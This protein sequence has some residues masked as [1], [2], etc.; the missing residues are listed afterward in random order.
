MRCGGRDKATAGGATLRAAWRQ[1]WVRS[2]SPPGPLNACIASLRFDQNDHP[3]LIAPSRAMLLASS[4]KG[5]AGQALVACSAVPGAQ[6]C[7]MVAADREVSCFRVSPLPPATAAAAAASKAEA[8]LS[9][10]RLWHQPISGGRVEWAAALA[11]DAYL[12]VTSHGAAAPARACVVQVLGSAAT[13]GFGAGH[14]PPHLQRHHVCASA[15]LGFAEGLDE[16]PARPA[17]SALLDCGDGSLALALALHQVRRAGVRW[18]GCIAWAAPALPAAAMLE[19]KLGPA[20]SH[21]C[22]FD[23]QATLHL[24]RATRGPGGTWSLAATPRALRPLLAAVP[25]ELGWQRPRAAAKVSVA[26]AAGARSSVAHTTLAPWCL[27][28]QQARWWRSSRWRSPAPASA[29]AAPRPAAAPVPACR[30]RCCTPRTR[31]AALCTASTWRAWSWRR[32]AGRRAPGSCG[33]HGLAVG[34][35]CL[36]GSV[37]GGGRGT[38]VSRAIAVDT[39]PCLPPSPRP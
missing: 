19:S 1:G 24:V 11:P 30:S 31:W 3:H 16:P 15:E 29:A 2:V 39:R 35:A 14:Q 25:G 33:A 22:S 7:L 13:P 34:F 37:A 10:A 8:A 18:L 17:F 5:A 20:L 21:L 26:A 36:G 12:L 6:G 38:G 32:R 4:S 23:P 27:L 9:P 28:P